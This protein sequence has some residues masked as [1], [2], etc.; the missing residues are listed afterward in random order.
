MTPRS[1]I[2]VFLPGALGQR[3]MHRMTS[4][5]RRS[6]VAA[7]SVVIGADSRGTLVDASTIG[8]ALL[9][10]PR[11]RARYQTP[12]PVPAGQAQPDSTRIVIEGMREWKNTN[13]L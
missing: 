1:A 13:K 6:I 8:V 5:P 10:R 2:L 9:E 4:R 12:Q 11:H 3:G 7:C